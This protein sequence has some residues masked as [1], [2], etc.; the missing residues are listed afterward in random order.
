MFILKN[1]TKKYILKE[2]QH[3]VFE[4]VNLELPDKGIVFVIGNSGSGKTTLLNILG[5]IDKPTAGNIFYDDLCLSKLNNRQLDKYRANYISFV[6][7]DFNLFNNDTVENNILIAS[8][9]KADIKY[10]NIC[11]KQVGLENFNKRKINTLSGG[12]KQRVA[13]AFALYKKSKVIL[14]DE[15]T[16]NLDEENSLEILNL[17]SQL[18]KTSLVL[19]VTH[20]KHLKDKFEGGII[21]IENKKIIIKK[22]YNV[23]NNNNN[24][25]EL[26]KNDNPLLLGIKQS[27]LLS[28]KNLYN[29]KILFL[30]SFILILLQIVLSLSTFSLSSFSK[31]DV[32]SNTFKNE[33]RYVFP[34]DTVIN[35][36]R[37]DS[38]GD[39]IGYQSSLYWDSNLYKSKKEDCNEI[40][41]KYGGEEIIIG[42]TYTF[43]LRLKDFFTNNTTNHNDFIYSTSSFRKFIA[44]DNFS[45]FKL[46]LLYGS[47]PKS[48]DEVLIYDYMEKIILDNF[49]SNKSNLLGKEF[50]HSLYK[51]KFKVVGVISTTY[52]KTISYLQDISNKDN[53]KNEYGGKEADLKIGIDILDQYS[54]VIGL[55]SFVN[56]NLNYSSKESFYPNEMVVTNLNSKEEKKFYDNL[57]FITIKNTSPF[58]ED[59]FEYFNN[60]LKSGFIL[61]KDLLSTFSGVSLTDFDNYNF[62]SEEKGIQG[63][64]DSYDISFNIPSLF[65][66][67]Y[68]GLYSVLPFDILGVTKSAATDKN[69]YYICD[70]EKDIN[71]YTDSVYGFNVFSYFHPSIIFSPSSIKNKKIINSLIPPIQNLPD[72]FYQSKD[73]N[74]IEHTFCIHDYL[75]NI[76]AFSYN[77]MDKV[78]SVSKKIL[79]GVSIASALIIFLFSFL[80][81]KNNSYTIAIL[82]ARGVN[83][84][85]LVFIFGLS[86]LIIYISSFIISIPISILVVSS[87]NNIFTQSLIW[88]TLFYKVNILPVIYSFIFG[89]IILII[90]IFIPLLLLVRKRPVQMINNSK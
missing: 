64:I 71:L 63:F 35:T 36:N 76:I 75:N 51:I 21:Q 30:S 38:F 56:N 31:E 15:P 89:L 50:Y 37:K 55:K 61:N 42:E 44:V 16:G 33:S 83:N 6:F 23:V 60:N 52:Q 46:P 2:K 17:L 49:V 19:I 90:S 62:D 67:S 87:F 3:I 68:Y 74:F 69:I 79:I 39:Y 22:K 72:S 57:N 24:N 25:S 8:N 20:N 5:G 53:Y 82:K 13:I 81:I 29:S 34:I 12:E 45:N 40:V 9:K 59:D 80:N 18:S 14:C 66:D 48:E 85:S 32:Y 86:P 43:S 58:N 73:D 70:N 27:F 28:L 84:I 26:I 65:E 7:Q 78:T 88:D 1:V 77:Y 4:N 47:L 54:N 11:L 41:S 10:L